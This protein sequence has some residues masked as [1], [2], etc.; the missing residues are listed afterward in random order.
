LK[1]VT[2]YHSC[3]LGC[4]VASFRVRCQTWTYPAFGWRSVLAQKKSRRIV[5]AS[6]KRP[7]RKQSENPEMYPHPAAWHAGAVRCRLGAAEPLTDSSKATRHTKGHPGFCLR[8]SNLPR[9]RYL[10][11]RPSILDP[12]GSWPFFFFFFAQWNLA[13]ETRP[14][15]QQSRG[16]TMI[17]LQ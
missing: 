15:Y 13:I 5:S 9:N 1:A 17:S 16:E 3:G 4:C 12:S 6:K 10:C 11:R 14:V 8:R 2:F 7:R